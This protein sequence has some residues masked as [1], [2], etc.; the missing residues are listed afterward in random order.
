MSSADAI[1][2]YLG[3]YKYELVAVHVITQCETTLEQFYRYI[4]YFRRKTILYETLCHNR[5]LFD[6]A[7]ESWCKDNHNVSDFVD[8]LVQFDWLLLATY[9]GL[10]VAYKERKV[11]MPPEQPS[12]AKI[13][14]E[15]VICLTRPNDIVLAPCGHRS[16][17]ECA[18]TMLHG[19]CPICRSKIVCIVK[20]VYD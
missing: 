20:R 2:A 14:S 19:S 16:C 4:K 18:G 7:F 8:L 6:R 11:V 1:T 3:K 12:V 15:C 5:P 13:E 9:I 10:D 17:A